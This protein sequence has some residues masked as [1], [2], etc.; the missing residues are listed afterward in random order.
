MATPAAASTAV[1]AED[2]TVEVVGFTAAAVVDFTAAAPTA[3]AVATA[4]VDTDRFHKS[5]MHQS[6][7]CNADGLFCALSA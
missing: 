1:A 7:S 5:T 3:V 6:P 4:V 2:S